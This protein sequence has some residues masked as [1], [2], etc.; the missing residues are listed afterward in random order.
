M[1]QQL[2]QL[3]LSITASGDGL[4]VGGVGSPD[5]AQMHVESGGGD[6]SDGVDDVE[7]ALAVGDAANHRD[8]ERGLA[9]QR[10]HREIEQGGRV[11]DFDGPR[12]HRCILVG[13]VGRRG[14]HRV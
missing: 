1:G 2:Q 7:N 9:G 4:D 11:D 12:D 5:D 10:I 14:P 13:H 8:L 6:R 3:G